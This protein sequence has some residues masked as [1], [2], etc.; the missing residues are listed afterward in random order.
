[1]KDRKQI[2]QELLIYLNEYNEGPEDTVVIIDSATIEKDDYFVFFYNNEIFIK[3]GNIS[4]ALAGN[5]PIIINKHTGEKYITGTAESIEY[6][7][8]EYENKMREG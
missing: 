4:Y 8:E 3:E 6:Y 7:M 1:M 5:A 2:I